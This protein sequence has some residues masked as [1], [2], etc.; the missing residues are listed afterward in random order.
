MSADTPTFETLSVEPIDEHVAIVRLNRPD[1][2]NAL[3]SQ[4]GRRIG[5]YSTRSNREQVPGA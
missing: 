5:R 2:S 3:N 4:M 1:A